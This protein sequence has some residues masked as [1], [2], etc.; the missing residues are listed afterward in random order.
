MPSTQPRSLSLWRRGRRILLF[1]CCIC[2]VPAVLSW[3]NALSG[4]RNVGLGVASVEW[5]RQNGGNSL[6]SEIEN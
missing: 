6:V 5:L 1:A 4:P 2:L 3:V